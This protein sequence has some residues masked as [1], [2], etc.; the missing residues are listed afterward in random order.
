MNCHSTQEFFCAKDMRLQLGRHKTV[1]ENTATLANNVNNLQWLTDSEVANKMLVIHYCGGSVA[2][3]L[4]CRC[5]RAWVQIAVATLSGNSLKQTV[6]TY[7][8][9][10]TAGFAESNGSLPPGLWLTSPAGWL[11]RTGI[12]SGTLCSAVEYGL[13]LPF[14]PL[15]THC[16]AC[17][18][19]VPQ[20][21]LKAFIRRSES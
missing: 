19:T 7:R 18:T 5:S 12:S 3:W 10:V 2:E 17:H 21:R 16:Y 13:P 11:T 14:Y 4:A 1:S 15:L 8:A 9:Y 20:T 6:H